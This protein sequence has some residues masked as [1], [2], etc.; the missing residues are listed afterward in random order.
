MKF[1]NHATEEEQ[2]I[3]NISLEK[4]EQERVMSKSERRALHSWV[5]SGKDPYTNGF[6]YCFENGY[7]MDFIEAE[8]I[9]LELYEEHKK[10]LS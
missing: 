6:G 7:Q 3:L 4:Y 9:C 5:A 10:T 2:L 1:K 8:R